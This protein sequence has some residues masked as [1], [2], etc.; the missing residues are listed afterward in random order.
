MN[1]IER[2][3]QFIQKHHGIIRFKDLGLI[4]VTIDGNTVVVTTL[5]KAVERQKDFIRH[6]A[7]KRAWATR[8]KNQ[9]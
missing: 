9:N 6:R 3:I 7:A 5:P 4:E 1:D 2:A 8:N